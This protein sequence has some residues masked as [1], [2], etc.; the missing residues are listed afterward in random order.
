MT[1]PTVHITLTLNGDE[2]EAEVPGS[3]TALQLI[4]E[5]F[6]LKGTKEGCG[7]GECG[8]CTIIVDGE[9][10]NA[11]LMLAAKL[12]GCEVRTVEGLGTPEAL[13]PIQE[14]FVSRHAVQCGFCT[15]GLVMSTKALLDK[16]PRPTRQDIANA[17]T[18]NLCRCTGYAHIVAAVEEA[19][20]RISGKE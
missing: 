12:D 10:V 6:K 17:V 3:L 14:A 7:V 11:C 16:N 1:R 5:V 19:A 2:Q 15:P 13:H 9:A 20:A 8:A 18:G 4:R